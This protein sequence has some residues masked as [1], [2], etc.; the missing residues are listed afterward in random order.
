MTVTKSEAYILD[1]YVDKIE[2]GPEYRRNVYI[3]NCGCF[4]TVWHNMTR[5]IERGQC[6]RIEGKLECGCHPAWMNSEIAAAAIR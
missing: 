4:L 6:G 2:F 3:C 5:G 1:N